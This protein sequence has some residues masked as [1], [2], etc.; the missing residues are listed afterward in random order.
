MLATLT[1]EMKVEN[2][3]ATEETTTTL[4][5]RRDRLWRSTPIP[6]STTTRILTRT[7]RRR[8]VGD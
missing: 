7:R 1:A 8:P 5:A 3:T 2:V 6:P 4:V